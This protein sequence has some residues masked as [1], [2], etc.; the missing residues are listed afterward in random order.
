MRV[1][2]SIKNSTGKRILDLLASVTL[3][4]M[5]LIVARVATI[6]CGDATGRFKNRIVRYSKVDA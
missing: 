5:E 3:T 6:G 2:R 4:F 1:F